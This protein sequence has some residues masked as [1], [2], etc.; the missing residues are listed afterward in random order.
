MKTLIVLIPLADNADAR[1]QCENIES[2]RINDGSTD[3]KVKEAIIKEID[4]TYNLSNIEIWEMTD[5]MDNV[6]NQEFEVEKY[7][8]T[9]VLVTGTFN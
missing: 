8:M 9:Y 6:N 5:F 1:K 3:E 4:D 7:F 2:L